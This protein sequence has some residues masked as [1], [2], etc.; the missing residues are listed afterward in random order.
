MAY[1]RYG[2]VL[3]NAEKRSKT[4][5]KIYKISSMFDSVSFND[6]YLFVGV[7]VFYPVSADDNEMFHPYIGD[8][9][10]SW[11]DGGVLW[12]EK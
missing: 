12:M 4:N 8:E 3:T 1:S 9:F 2:T 11:I 5:V 7:P 6:D 10:F